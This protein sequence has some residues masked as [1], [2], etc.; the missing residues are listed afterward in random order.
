MKAYRYDQS[1]GPTYIFIEG[2]K[3]ETK[4]ELEETEEKKEPPKFLKIIKNIK[5]GEISL[6]PSH[7]RDDKALE[8][9]NASKEYLISLVDLYKLSISFINSS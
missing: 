3:F 5:T 2:A 8:W 7:F 4:P 1:H 6:S 9:K